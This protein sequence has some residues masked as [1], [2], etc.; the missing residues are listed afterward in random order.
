MNESK[1]ARG[2]RMGETEYS[3]IRER[4]TG[5]AAL[6]W[7]KSERE[8]IDCE[9]EPRERETRRETGKR[10][11]A[12]TRT[13]RGDRAKAC[14]NERRKWTIIC[15]EQQQQQPRRGL[16]KQLKVSQSVTSQD[17]L[18]ARLSRQEV[19]IG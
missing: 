2:E 12:Q 4:L 18:L 13:R 15:V 8:A 16:T 5:K 19:E 7:R 17:P 3:L 1:A 6:A 14:S 10:T 11:Q 9:Q